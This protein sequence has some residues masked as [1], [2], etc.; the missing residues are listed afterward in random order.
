MKIISTKTNY[1][2]LKQLSFFLIF[3]LFLSFS[4]NSTKAHANDK[5]YP[6]FLHDLKHTGLSQYR[7]TQTNAIKW[8]ILTGGEIWSTPIIGSDNTIY[9]SST[10]GN[11]FAFNPDG[12]AFPCYLLC[13]QDTLMGNIL[14]EKSLTQRYVSTSN[15]FWNMKKD[16]LSSCVN[17]WSKEICKTCIGPQFQ[18]TGKICEPPHWFCTLHRLVIEKVLCSIHSMS[19]D[20][21][22]WDKFF[23]TMEQ[24]KL[25]EQQFIRESYIA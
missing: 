13:N 15:L 25:E 24:F 6:M 10:D 17:C 14:N 20:T 1:F 21:Q 7:G 18:S 9:V 5:Q 23:K 11:L 8:S 22:H 3:F 19:K 16:S 2:P 4:I 12:T